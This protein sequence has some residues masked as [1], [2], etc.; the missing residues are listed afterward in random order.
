VQRSQLEKRFENQQIQGSL[1][2]VLRH[3]DIPLGN[4]VVLRGYP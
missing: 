4:L 3:V 2:I 1:Q